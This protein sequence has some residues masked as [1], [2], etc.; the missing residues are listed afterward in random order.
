[1]VVLSLLVNILNEIYLH[2]YML[3]HMYPN[4]F[5][6][7]TIQGCRQE[8]E[9]RVQLILYHKVRVKLFNAMPTK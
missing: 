9:R 4:R 2:M 8:F 7:H 5:F 3:M 6:P 1:M